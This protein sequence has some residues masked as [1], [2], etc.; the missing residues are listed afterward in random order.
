M[1]NMLLHSKRFVFV[2]ILIYIASVLVYS[3]KTY[4]SE[5]MLY[6]RSLD[7]HL[8]QSATV[9]STLLSS[10]LFSEGGVTKQPGSLNLEMLNNSFVHLADQF[11]L[12]HLFAVS[13]ERGMVS[14]VYG[15]KSPLETKGFV[16]HVISQTGISLVD[17]LPEAPLFYTHRT[18]LNN[19]RGIVLY[20]KTQNGV[21]YWLGGDTNAGR[22]EIESLMF[23]TLLVSVAFLLL[24]AIIPLLYL[25]ALWKW[26]FFDKPTKLLNRTKL[27]F[28]IEGM[29]NPMLIVINITCFRGINDYFGDEAGFHILAQLSDRC[30]EILPKS[31]QLYHVSGTDLAVL[32]NSTLS[33]RGYVCIEELYLDDF[34]AYLEKEH[35][36]Y[37]GENIPLV[38]TLGVASKKERLIE[39]TYKAVDQALK[40][41]LPY[42]VYDSSLRDQKTFESSIQWMQKVKKS[43]EQDEIVPVFQPV[44]DNLSGETAF[45]E[46]LVRLK[47][48]EDELPPHIF[49]DMAKKSR[50]Y[51]NITRAMIKKAF[52]IFEKSKYG[53]SINLS[54]EDLQSADMR[55]YIISAVRS[56]PHPENITFEMVAFEEV[57]TSIDV[58]N[59]LITLKKLG[60]HL[61]IDDFGTDCSNLAHILH[62]S[63][64]YIKLDQQII[65]DIDKNEN[66]QVFVETI[67]DF[68]RKMKIKTVA[69]YVSSQVIHNKIKELGVD[70]SQGYYCG[71]PQ[72]SID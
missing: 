55:K 5:S 17:N 69:K 6:L 15:N 41:N 25:N 32:A 30:R 68:S 51:P 37:R 71:R 72:A 48:V 20:F 52:K 13:I 10:H 11:K 19:Y 64:D 18:G 57:W 46:G 2:G 36:H 63:V 65:Q 23:R 22:M 3:L 70:Y 26:V 31:V 50:L 1:Q 14:N 67:V 29:P 35:Y 33:H 49:L 66:H 56:F 58:K 7:A 24:G 4:N 44:I 39:R 53:L 62:L 47:G 42:Y 27:S 34:I 9:A 8:L 54:W 60:A 61:A 59:D 40:E 16:N 38:V 43:I 28:D 45:F 21:H 12:L